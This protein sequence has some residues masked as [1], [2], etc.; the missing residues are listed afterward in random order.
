MLARLL[1]ADLVGGAQVGLGDVPT[2]LRPY[3]VLST[4]QQFR[5]NLA[6]VLCEAPARVVIDEFTSVVDRKF[7]FR[8]M[9]PKPRILMVDDDNDFAA[10]TAGTELA[11]DIQKGFLDRLA[12]TP[13]RRWT[14]LVGATF[15]IEYNR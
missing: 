8:G 4:G 12:L 3:R 1:G 13:A 10:I 11:S 7:F 15:G 2:W 14:V 5:A 6:R 9:G